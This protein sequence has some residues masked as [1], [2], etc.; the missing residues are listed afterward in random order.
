MKSSRTELE[1]DKVR[2]TKFIGESLQPFRKDRQP[3]PNDGIILRTNELADCLVGI[4]IGSRK[5]IELLIWDINALHEGPISF[6]NL[7]SASDQSPQ[8]IGIS[9]QSLQ[10]QLM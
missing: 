8:G 6:K 7:R 10:L 4:S 2:R 3:V 9:A 5:C 1:N